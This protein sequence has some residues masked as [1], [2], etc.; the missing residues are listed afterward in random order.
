M[1]EKREKRNGHEA[2]RDKN[3]SNCPA[4]HVVE[5]HRGGMDVRL[6]KKSGIVESAEEWGTRKKSTTF[7]FW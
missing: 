4:P 2:G 6:L 7:L 1:R 5:V 3:C